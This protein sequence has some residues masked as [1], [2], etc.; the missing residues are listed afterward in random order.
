[1]RGTAWKYRNLPGF[2]AGQ[3]G[4]IA[5]PAAQQASAKCSSAADTPAAAARRKMAIRH[6]HERKAR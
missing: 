5:T 2:P 4:G 1:A 3:T 6:D